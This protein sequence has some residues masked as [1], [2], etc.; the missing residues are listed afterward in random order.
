MKKYIRSSSTFPT[1]HQYKGHKIVKIRSYGQELY[2]V[3]G[4]PEDF[5]KKYWD[6][7]F[8]TLKQAKKYIDE[9]EGE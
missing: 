2:R 5:Y 7:E 9:Y 1:S 6:G 3:H 8:E 4:M